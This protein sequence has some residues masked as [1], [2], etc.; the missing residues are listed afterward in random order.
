MLVS[1]MQLENVELFNDPKSDF[2][3]ISYTDEKA[4]NFCDEVF[5][6]NDE[7]WTDYDCISLDKL[8]KSLKDCGICQL[9]KS[10]VAIAH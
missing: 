9:T 3:G 1:R 6:N 2:G 8:N 5:N 7:M 4:D 10:Q